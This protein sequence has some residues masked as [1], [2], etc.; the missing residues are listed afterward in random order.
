M[1][2]KGAVILLSFYLKSQKTCFPEVLKGVELAETI[3]SGRGFV[4]YG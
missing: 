3:R 4:T 2:S 1:N